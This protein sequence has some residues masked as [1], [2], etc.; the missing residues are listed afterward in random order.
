MKRI[1][2]IIFAVCCLMSYIVY[3]QLSNKKEKMSHQTQYPKALV[4]Y[5][6]FSTLVADVEKHRADRLV[7]LDVFLKMS[8]EHNVVILDTRSD[9][10][11]N[12]KHLKGAIH[13]DFTDFTQTNLLKLIPDPNTKILIYCNNNF[14]GDQVDFA[15]KIAR[16]Q[17]AMETQI[18]SKQETVDAGVEYPYPHQPLRIWV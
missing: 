16:P 15:S 7:S 13:L 8:K 12:R 5:N 6:D 1:T 9:F 2:L 18:L 3:A 4:D 14:D 11:F 17:N 10:R